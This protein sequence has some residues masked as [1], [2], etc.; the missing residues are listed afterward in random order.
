MSSPS[1]LLASDLADPAV[2]SGL[3]EPAL[4]YDRL[5]QDSPLG[6][7][8]RGNLDHDGG[9]RGGGGGLDGGWR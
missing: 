9:G 7:P 5:D 8:R 3:Q 4:I 1:S 2:G 6:I